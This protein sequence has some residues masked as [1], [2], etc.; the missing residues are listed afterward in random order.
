MDRVSYLVKFNLHLVYGYVQ[1]EFTNFPA[2]FAARKPYQEDTVLAWHAAWVLQ[3]LFAL[4]RK[5]ECMNTDLRLE[6]SGAIVSKASPRGIS[7]GNRLN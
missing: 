7:I 5:S 1:I 4:H 3:F 6:A 2:V